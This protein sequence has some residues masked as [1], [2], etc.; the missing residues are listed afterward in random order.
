MQSRRSVGGT[1][2]IVAVC[3]LVVLLVGFAFYYLVKILGGGEE[4]SNAT[5]SGNLNLAKMAIRN[6]NIDA[7][8]LP[9][10]EVAAN[11]A[12]LG[13]TPDNKIDLLVYNRLVMHAYMVAHNAK[14]EAT[15]DATDHA[16]KVW[17]ALN[18]V[19]TYLH[20]HL[21]D[22]AFMGSHFNAL[23]GANNPKMLGGNTVALKDYDVAYMKRG[24]SANVYFDPA[25]WGAFDSAPSVPLNNTGRLSPSGN[26]YVAG[27]VPFGVTLKNGDTLYFSAIPLSPQDKPH[28]VNGPDFEANKSD[29][30]MTSMGS[31]AYPADTLP[32]NAFKSSGQSLDGKTNKFAN[33]LSHAIV[34]CLTTDYAVSMRLGYFMLKNG[35]SA[36]PPSVPMAD[37]S[38]DIF[39]NELIAGVVTQG[40]DPANIFTTD[41][42]LYDAWVTYNTGG[43]SVMPD[44]AASKSK[45]RKGDGMEVTEEDLKS[46]KT[47]RTPANTCSWMD[48]GVPPKTMCINSLT[49]FITGYDRAPGTTISGGTDDPWS[50]LE[51]WKANLLAVRATVPKPVPRGSPP[52]PD[53]GC[54]DSFAPPGDYG[55]KWFDRSMVYAAPPC[56]INFGKQ[57]SPGE[58]MEFVDAAPGGDGC[59]V[60]RVLTSLVKRCQQINPKLTLTDVKTALYSQPLNVGETLYL[61]SQDGTTLKLD[62]SPPA[63]AAPGVTADGP[64]TAPCG[65]PYPVNDTYINTCADGS[66]T[67]PKGDGNYSFIP[68]GSSPV[69]TCLDQINWIPSSGYRHLLGEL[70]FS[71]S[72]SGG[73]K[74]CDPQ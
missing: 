68:F 64:K 6:P 65:S 44:V 33:M 72:C 43:S 49:N 54:G 26:K 3:V 46:L 61:Y 24:G 7:A 41:Q 9:D 22:P 30:F 2:G 37:G 57:K 32:P 48:Y 62:K 45:F 8:S 25:L 51:V 18:C 5:D 56:P 34:S 35:P 59:A 63:W 29:A 60:G 53:V 13:D 58:L 39:N 38:N 27:Y 67:A 36:P 52:P 1:L 40:A 66:A 71:N 14:D 50:C 10:P 20:S 21:N 23:A 55:M 69:G 31:P 17:S 70:Y 19:G 4:L 16:K 28:L 11:F 12:F 73:G 74:F 15:D 42:G 47:P